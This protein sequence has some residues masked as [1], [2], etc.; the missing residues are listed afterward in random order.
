M[1]NDYILSSVVNSK[2]NK[3]KGGSHEMT[4]Y[5]F[6]TIVKV[7]ESGV[8]A[9]ANELANSLNDLVVERN[10]LAEENDKLKKYL[11]NATK[12]DN[13]N[14]DCETAEATE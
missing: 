6:D 7:L 10:N 14:C 13:C 9:L 12:C 8:P 3:Y 4:Q 2:S 5:Q 11:E 1:Y